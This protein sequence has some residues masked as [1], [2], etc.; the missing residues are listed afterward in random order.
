VLDIT[1]AM[2]FS[3]LWRDTP[4]IRVFQ[5]IAAG[6]LGRPAFEG[7]GATA[8]LGGVIHFFNAFSIVTVYHVA[9]SRISALTRR[10]VPCGLAYGVAVFLFMYYVVLPLSALNARPPYPWPT[11]V[12]GVLIHALAVGLP[13]ALFAR[14]ALTPAEPP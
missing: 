7:G 14:A 4:P 13:A 5:S 2:V 12:N 9:A 1:D 3:F 10:P 6:L 11:M 8:M